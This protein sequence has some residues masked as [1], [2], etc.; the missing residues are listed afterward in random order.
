MRLDTIEKRAKACCKF[1]ERSVPE[2]KP[3]LQFHR[4]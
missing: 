4:K 2:L 3:K 1:Q